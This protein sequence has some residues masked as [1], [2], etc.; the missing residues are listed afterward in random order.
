[1]ADNF[2]TY[3]I[4][5][6]GVTEEEAKLIVSQGIRKRVRRRQI[7]LHEGEVCRH[8]IFI[9]RGLLRSYL[10]KNDGAEYIMRFAAESSW[11]IDPESYHSGL[12]TKYN[13][14]A[15]EDCDVLLWTRDAMNRLSEEIPAL[16]AY[17]D[18]LK[19]NTLTASMGRIMMNI[20]GTS[21]EKYQEFVNTYPDVFNRVPLHM[22]ASYL[23]VS[24]ETLS[25]IR[26]TQMR[27]LKGQG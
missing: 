3:I 11:L 26:H 23:G 7:L 5:A 6:A 8:K 22:V 14:D 18:Q 12:P 17:S 25:R 13:V 19:T 10:L 16:K 2:E 9:E 21:E 20:S 15:L 1:M 4:Q 27:Q 24:R